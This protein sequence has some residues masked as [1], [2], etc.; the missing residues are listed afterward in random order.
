MKQKSD[1]N[2]AAYQAA[3]R[4][5]R[6]DNIRIAELGA[7]VRTNYISPSEIS[8]KQCNGKPLF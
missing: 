2:F 4:D 5:M 7:R 1:K 3:I 6:R 8:D